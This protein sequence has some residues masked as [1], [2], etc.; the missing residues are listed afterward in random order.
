MQHCT[1]HAPQRINFNVTEIKHVHGLAD[2]TKLGTLGR[3]CSG[4]VFI[5]VATPTVTVRRV[6]RGGTT[7]VL[8]TV[9]IFQSIGMQY[10][11]VVVQCHIVSFTYLQTKKQQNNTTTRTCVNTISQVFQVH[12]SRWLYIFISNKHTH[13]KKKSRRTSGR[14]SCAKI[15]KTW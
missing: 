11:A 9:G 10:T 5:P 7:V 1:Q 2:S 14:H 6:Q 4:F 8:M 3:T 12:R 15:C 13:K